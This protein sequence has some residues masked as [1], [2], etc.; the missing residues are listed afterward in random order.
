MIPVNALIPLRKKAY[1][2]YGLILLNCLVFLWQTAQPVP[3][4]NALFKEYAAVMCLVARAPFAPETLLDILRSMF[5]H[6][7]W[8]HLIGNMTFLWVFGRHVEAY[9]GSHRFAL[10]Y[11]AAGFVAAYAETLVNNGLCVPLVGASG[12]VAGVLG[13][14]L[15]LHPGSRI[16][17]Q[18]FI[19][20]FDLP[21]LL[22]LGY[23]FLVQ[24]FNGIASLGAVTVDGGVAFFAHIAGFVAGL[25]FAFAITMV[26]PP[27]ER[28]TYVD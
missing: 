3:G 9:F 22:I 10:F 5:F 7:G 2:T 11:L 4:L 19:F 1:V 23:W 13:S 14:Y 8:L 18:V 12:A 25:V 20:R 26:S 27:P 24:L 17:T 6:G 16:R 28:F 15:I 21:A